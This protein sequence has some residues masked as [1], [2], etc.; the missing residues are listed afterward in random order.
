M[1]EN[2]IFVNGIPYKIEDKLG[3]G[4]HSTVYNGWDLHNNQLVAIKIIRFTSKSIN[5]QL[6]IESRRQSFWKELEMLSYLL[7]TD[8]I[9]CVNYLDMFTYLN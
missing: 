2:R 5:S 9:S 4:L 1:I 8:M 6:E 3:Q 7:F